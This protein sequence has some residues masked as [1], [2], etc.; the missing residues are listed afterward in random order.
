MK[1]EIEILKTEIELEK[2]RNYQ[3]PKREKPKE[4]KR[5]LRFGNIINWA[6][7]EDRDKQEK[8]IYGEN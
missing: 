7:K 5:N 1:K 3:Q 6:S 2:N 4:N 8:D